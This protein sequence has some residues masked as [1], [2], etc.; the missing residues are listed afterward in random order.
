MT[1]DGEEK[2]IKYC[3][4]TTTLADSWRRYY[5][6]SA[7]GE[8]WVKVGE[9]IESGI[10]LIPEEVKKEIGVGN[11]DLVTWLKNYHPYVIPISKDQIEVV[12]D[13]VNKYPLVS[14]YKKPRPYHADPFVVAVGK[15]YSCTVVSYERGNNS[16]DHP[17]IGDLCEEYKVDFCSVSDFFERQGWKFN[18]K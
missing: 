2:K 7:F 12:S 8:L 6:P 16:K 18:I 4:D 3:F 14:Q 5:R 9:L 13:I 10:V 17:R 15:I 1:T 11:D